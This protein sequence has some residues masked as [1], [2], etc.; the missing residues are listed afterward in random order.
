MF[1]AHRAAES[2]VFDALRAAG[3][4]DLTLAQCRIG[5]RL[6]PAGI[7]LTDLAEQARVTKQT[8]GALVDELERAGYVV[9]RPDPADARARLVML[10]R[11][12]ERLCAAAAAELAKVEGEWRAHLGDA[13]FTQMR[14]GLLALREITDPYR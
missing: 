7:R 14:G 13:A 1:I 5:Q 4:D 9:R 8:A 2:R 3:F 6:N 11:R 10:S 12:G